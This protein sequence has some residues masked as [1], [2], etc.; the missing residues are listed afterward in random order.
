M[1]RVLK[2]EGLVGPAGVQGRGQGGSEGVP[3]EARRDGDVRPAV[4][5]LSDAT[6]IDGNRYL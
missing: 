2:P 1:R 4:A 5:A 3:G 6:S